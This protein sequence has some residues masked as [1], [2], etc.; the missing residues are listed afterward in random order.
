MVLVHCE[1]CNKQQEVTPTRAKKYRFCSYECKGKNQSTNLVKENSPNWQDGDRTKVCEHC[2]DEFSIKRGRAMSL[3]RNQ[4]FCSHECGVLGRNT[5]GDQNPNWKGGHSDRSAKQHKWSTNVISRDRA[6]CQH[7][8]ATGVELHAHHIKS[9]KDHPELRWD[10]S[11][12]LTLCH[13]CHWAVHSATNANAVNSGKPLT[14]QAEG[15]PEPSFDGNIVEGVTT[16]GRAYRRVEANCPTCGKFVSKRL[17]DAKGKAFIA[18]S[19]SCAG[20]HNQ[21]LRK[22]QR[23]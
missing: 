17:S 20:T 18:C 1:W 10:L 6:T 13:Q 23:Q 12:G 4:R 3:F 2:G 9:F 15:N 16:R 7:C 11:N 14:V 19:R 8:G 21:L 5:D 22:R